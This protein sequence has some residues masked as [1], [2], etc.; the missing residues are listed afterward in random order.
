MPMKF[1]TRL[2]CAVFFFSLVLFVLNSS[3]RAQDDLLEDSGGTTK[4][5]MIELS[6]NVLNEEF[7][8]VRAT[9]TIGYGESDVTNPYQNPYL[10][11]IGGFPKVNSRNSFFW[12]SGSTE[13]TI[14]SGEITSEIKRTYLRPLTYVKPPRSF[15][16]CHFA[17]LSPVLI[18][19]VKGMYLDPTREKQEKELATKR[20]MPTLVTAQAGRLRIRIAGTM[21]SGNVWM[22]GYD[23]I[24]HSYVEYNASFAGAL[25]NRVPPQQQAR[26]PLRTPGGFG[27]RP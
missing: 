1:K 8:S 23:V 21:I 15:I 2:L 9:I 3:S 13:L 27:S 12:D 24:E 5:F 25:A 26:D 4:T 22:K 7:S 20:S 18:K 17:Y 10:V 6:G 14:L 19:P 11:I 16:Q